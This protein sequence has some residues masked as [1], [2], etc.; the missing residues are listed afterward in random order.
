MATETEQTVERFLRNK[1]Y[2][3]TEGRY[4]RFNVARGLD[5]V[6]LEESKKK[7]EIAAAIRRYVT[8]QEV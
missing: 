2:L 6:G 4:Y 3:D 7:K 8:S 1:A 5:E